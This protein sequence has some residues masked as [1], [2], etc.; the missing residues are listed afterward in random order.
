MAPGPRSGCLS[1]RNPQRFA[2]SVS[3]RAAVPADRTA[4]ESLWQ[5]YNAFYRE[6]VPAAVTETTWQRW[7]DPHSAMHLLV[8]EREGCLV[9]FAAYLFHPSSWA[10]GPYCYLEDL[11]TAEPAR[12]TGA[13]RALIVA[14]SDAARAAGAERLYWVTHHSNAEAQ[15]LYNKVAKNTGFIQ[16][17][18][19]LPG[20][21]ANAAGD[22]RD[23]ATQW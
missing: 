4:F 8:A 21:T 19:P 5:G 3:I 6:A 10:I 22:G 18:R 14:V 7:L 12:G 17:Q 15:V 23:T 16:Y 13:G 11:F 20:I 1:H 9:A 2:M